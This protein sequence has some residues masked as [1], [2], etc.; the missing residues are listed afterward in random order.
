MITLIKGSFVEKLRV[1]DFHILTSTTSLCPVGMCLKK[2]LTHILTSPKV[3]VSSW[4]L[5]EVE[6]RQSRV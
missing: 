1:A 3:T 6:K 5:R 2:S 4:H